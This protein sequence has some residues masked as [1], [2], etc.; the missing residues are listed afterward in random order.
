MEI[1]YKNGKD[2]SILNDERKIK[3][4]Y[5]K[6][7]INIMN[8]LTE[9]R[10]ATCLEDIPICPPPRRHKLEGEDRWSVRYTKNYRII[11]EPYGE[12]N[13]NDLKT[14][15]EIRILELEDYH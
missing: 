13:I 2:E 10:A 12:Y 4:H 3:K 8:R 9:L 5:N 15:K 7:S 6:S 11:F 1:H 14:I